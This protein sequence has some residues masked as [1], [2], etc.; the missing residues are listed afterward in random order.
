MTPGVLAVSSVPRKF[1]I[2]QGT[3]YLE[4]MYEETG[5]KGNTQN[6]K[7]TGNGY[8]KL[9]SGAKPKSRVDTMFRSAE[10]SLELEFLKKSAAMI[11]KNIFISESGSKNLGKMKKHSIVCT[12]YCQKS[13]AV[14]SRWCSS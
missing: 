4:P 1:S 14:Y 12:M 9:P 11:V 10:I 6:S 8:S 13:I 3:G 7:N 2:G 5:I